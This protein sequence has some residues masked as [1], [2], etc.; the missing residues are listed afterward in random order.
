MGIHFDHEWGCF[1]KVCNFGGMYNTIITYVTVNQAQA[2]ISSCT[3]KTIKRI[4]TIIAYIIGC[5]IYL[6]DMISFKTEIFTFNFS[7]KT[8]WSV[9]P[10]FC[11]LS[12]HMLNLVL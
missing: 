9:E 8:S 11:Y 12:R 10:H 3:R 5:G 1:E 6:C 2:G 7:Y 4:R